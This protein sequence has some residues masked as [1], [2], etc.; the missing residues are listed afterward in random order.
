MNIF[1]LASYLVEDGYR[2]L[3]RRFVGSRWAGGLWL[4][5]DQIPPPVFRANVP[6][7]TTGLMDALAV[8]VGT[9]TN[10]RTYD[11]EVR[12]FDDTYRTVP[13]GVVAYDGARYACN[14]F[15]PSGNIS[16]APWIL[17]GTATTPDTRTL[18]TPAIN[19]GI[20]FSILWNSRKTLRFYN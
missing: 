6:S 16:S 2:G 4:S 13:G 5:S 18:N 1:R 15:F 20:V 8:G 7:Q 11:L 12:D 19:D 14:A 17:L 9:A 3:R 10:A